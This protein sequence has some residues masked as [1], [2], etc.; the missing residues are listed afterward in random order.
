MKQ[1]TQQLSLLFEL[2]GARPVCDLS[3]GWQRLKFKLAKVTAEEGL[4]EFDRFILAEARRACKRRQ[5]VTGYRW[6]VDHMIPVRRG[7]L[8]RYDN[9]QVIPRWL[10]LWKGDKMVLVK[11]GEY[12]AFLPGGRPSLF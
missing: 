6:D 5:A 10:N 8:H 7:G 2:D 1:L 4:T 11:V 12:A 3:S 9:I